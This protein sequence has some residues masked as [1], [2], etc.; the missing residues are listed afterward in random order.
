MTILS[1]LCWVSVSSGWVTLTKAGVQAG[2][3]PANPTLCLLYMLST[4]VL[5]SHRAVAP[6]ADRLQLKFLLLSVSKS[7]KLSASLMA[8]LKRD[9]G[10]AILN[11]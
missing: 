8:H 4:R 10:K 2:P 5:T 9:V 7:S 3:A 11:D 1:F 6:E